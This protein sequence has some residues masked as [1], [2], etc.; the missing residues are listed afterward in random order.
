MRKTEEDNRTWKN[1][2][3]T[4]RGKSSKAISTTSI[5][6]FAIFPPHQKKRKNY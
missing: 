1:E 2:T 6:D 4:E 5:K 3:K